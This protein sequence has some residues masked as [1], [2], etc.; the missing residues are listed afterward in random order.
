METEDTSTEKISRDMAEEEFARFTRAWDID[1]NTDNMSGEDKESFDQQKGRIVNQIVAGHA[2]VDEGGDIHYTLKYP[3]GDTAKLHFRVP[4]GNAY[5]S[6]DSF[7]DR[8]N[9]GKI[10]AFM[11]SM[12]KQAPKFFSNMD[13]RDVKF[14]QG[15]AVLFLAS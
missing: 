8:Q 15:V 7:K 11:G 1:V 10:N 9:I 3:K 5:T 2:T 12:T 14:C 6:M 4:S 13:A